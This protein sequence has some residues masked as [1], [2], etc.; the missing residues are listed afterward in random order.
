[1]KRM[2]KP[3][4]YKVASAITLSMVALLLATC[5]SDE[6]NNATIRFTKLAEPVWE[7]TL[8]AADPSIIRDGDTLR[9]YYSSLILNPE[10]KLVIAG[11]KSTDGVH[12]I[13]ANE[14]E[15]AESVALTV[16]TGT[17]DD[18]LET[19]SVIRRNN[20][21]W[22]YFCGYP[23]EADVVGKLVAES[24]IGLAKSDNAVTFT[25]QFSN[26]ILS[27]GTTNSKDANAMFSPTVI[28]EGNLYYMLYRI[29]Y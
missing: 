15:R 10:E 12:W 13:P 19:V 8:T 21:L 27:R 7:G 24:D 11:A 9:M 1:M 3:K 29:L 5:S 22:M 20:E 25:R 14:I 6:S 17:W 18:H 16:P 2:K 23:D 28:K 4:T 26:A